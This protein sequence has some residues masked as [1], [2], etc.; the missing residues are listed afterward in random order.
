MPRGRIKSS[1][2]VVGVLTPPAKSIPSIPSLRHVEQ[3]R[4]AIIRTLDDFIRAWAAGDA[5]GMAGCFHPDRTA[6]LVQLLP[7][8]DGHEGLRTLSRSEGIQVSLD[9][10]IHQTPRHHRAITVLDL[11]EQ[12]ASVRAELDDRV[13]YAHLSFTG[14]RWAIVNLMWDWVSSKSRRSA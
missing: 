11:A 4:D 8:S 2:M 12:S 9:A 14:E 13:A 5:E 7:N 10:G 1:P 3:D 6:R